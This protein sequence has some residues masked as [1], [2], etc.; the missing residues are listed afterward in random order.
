MSGPDKKTAPSAK[1]P[2][3]EQI[4][5]TDYPAALTFTVEAAADAMQ[6]AQR[7]LRCAGA[8]LVRGDL[9]ACVGAIEATRKALG[10]ALDSLAGLIG[11]A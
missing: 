10:A 4:K 7:Q 9:P 11:S 8:L 6:F 1:T 2:R 5:H 3:A